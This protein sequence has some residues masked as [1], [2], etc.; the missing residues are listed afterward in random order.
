MT[1]IQLCFSAKTEEESKKIVKKM[2]KLKE[3]LDK[4]YGDEYTIHSCHLTPEI[5]KEKGFSPTIVNAFVT[6]FGNKYICEVTA[7]SFDD[8][9]AH[10]DE[11]RRKTAEKV[12]KLIILAESEVSNV[13]LELEYFSNKK[14][15]IF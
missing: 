9:M 4:E 7:H 11:Y 14:V 3:T 15:I 1:K 6:I 12:D 10:M 2:I 13:K 5:V 8:A